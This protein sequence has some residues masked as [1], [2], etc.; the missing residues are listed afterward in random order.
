MRAVIM[1]LGTR[2]ATRMSLLLKRIPLATLIP[3]FTAAKI[4]SISWI[5]STVLNTPSS[6]WASLLKWLCLLLKVPLPATSKTITYKST[7]LFCFISYV[8]S[9]RVVSLDTEIQFISSGDFLFC[10]FWIR[11]LI[12]NNK[13]ILKMELDEPSSLVLDYVGIYFLIDRA[14][15]MTT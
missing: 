1:P 13:S 5:L 14:D 10:G 9:T 6:D 2:L 15:S 4:R 12:I 7:K 11:T 3:I 8:N